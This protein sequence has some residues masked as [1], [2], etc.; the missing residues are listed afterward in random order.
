MNL[1]IPAAGSSTRFP[2]LKP[3]WLLTHPNGNLMVAEAIR[4]L[5]MP[6]LERIYLT[7]LSEHVEKFKIMDGIKKQFEQIG[8]GDKLT[9]IQLDKPTRSQ[10]ETVARA[11]EIEKITGPICIKDSDNYFRLEVPSQNFVSVVNLNHVGFVN[12]SNKSYAAVNENNLV[13]NIAEKQ[14]ISHFFCCGAYGFESATEYLKY[15][16][17]LAHL[18]NLYVSHIIYQMIL[19]NKAF[20]ALV[21]SDYSDWGTLKDWNRY[22]AQFGTLFIDLDGTLVGN[23]G[24]YFDPVWGS[25][26]AIKE[27]VAI[28]NRLYRSG[29]VQ[30]VITTSRREEARQLTLDQLKRE[31]IEYH[32]IVFGMNH[33]KRIVINDYAPTNPFKSCDALNIA[34]NST[35]L[36]EM[37]EA[38]L[39]IEG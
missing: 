28:I 8:L 38:V 18:D 32:Q 13:T 17:A 10:P 11:I 27:N 7:I 16:H 35:E 36:T 4:G 26:K 21:C 19:E 22:K 15:F 33:G 2:N 6:G 9:V 24:G 29:K 3:K 1:I 5:K 20:P 37:L 23:S 14:V 25:T 39:Q 31:G 34:R 12:P 30:I